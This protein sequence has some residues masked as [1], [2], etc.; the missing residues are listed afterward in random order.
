MVPLAFA[1]HRSLAP[2]MWF[3]VLLAGLELMV[4]HLL[5]SLLWSWEVAAVL[6]VLTVL[7]MLWLVRL[8]R[9]FRRLPVLVGDR[10]I[11]LRTGTLQVVRLTPSA[12]K[13]IRSSWPSGFLNDRAV[14]NLALLS[15]PN[16]VIDL[17]KPIETSGVR[18]RAITS[19]AHRLDDPGGFSTA[20]AGLRAQHDQGATG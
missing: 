8:I 3:L 9:S 19:I 17:V 7:T 12:I 5:I 1:Y 18:K 16:L 6:S 10:E 13:G 2:M 15:H 4:V 14:L 20:I 11:V